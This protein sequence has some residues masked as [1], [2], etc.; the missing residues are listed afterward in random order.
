VYDII[1]IQFLLN[2]V[3]MTHNAFMKYK[4]RVVMFGPDLDLKGGIS[5]VVLAYLKAGLQKK[6]SLIFI[7]TTRDGT[8]RSKIILFLICIFKSLKILLINKVDICHFH[9]SHRGSFYRKL[10]LVGIAKLFRCKVIAQIH[11]SDF[12]D[13]ITKRA[14][15]RWLARRM[16]AAAD[17]VIVLSDRWKAKMASIS[18]KATVVK[19]FNPAC[20]PE[21]RTVRKSDGALTVLFLGELS[22]RKGTYDLLHCIKEQRSYYE[23]KRVKFIIAG[24][25]DVE[26]VKKI[27][28]RNVL[29]DV[30]SVPGWVS[31]DV[32]K[33]YLSN[34][35]I[36][37]LPSYHEQMPM[38]ILEAMAYGLPII[39]T[40]VAGIPEMVDDGLNGILID[41]G[42]TEKL[43][44]ALKE[45]IESKAC[46][47][48]MGQ[49]S[50]KIVAEKFDGAIIIER[51]VSIY[52]NMM[53]VA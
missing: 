28:E 50:M 43:N 41:P 25:G 31:G 51:L 9:V 16:L 22:L 4:P 39:S 36:Y 10:V 2:P 18:K 42:D 13:F 3:T 19:L 15:N 52:H 8:K 1:K 5:F 26:E 24:N 33:S 45:L 35:D 37:I 23:K 29:N 30:V 6:V 7:P 46:R 47:G 34:A 17:V 11:G 14:V 21:R 53:N 38:S 49:K 48:V 27:V 12:E 20:P 44:S 32:K 40:R